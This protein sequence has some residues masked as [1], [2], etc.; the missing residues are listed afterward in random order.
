[1]VVKSFIILATGLTFED[2]QRGLADNNIN[3]ID[4]R[5]SM[6]VKTLGKLPTAN[7]L[8]SEF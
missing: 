2:V 3:L 6:E 4:V 7:N 5:T 8:P 1:M